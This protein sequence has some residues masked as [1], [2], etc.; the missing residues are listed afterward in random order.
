[1]AKTSPFVDGVEE[2]KWYRPT[3]DYSTIVETPYGKY[4]STDGMSVVT[5]VQQPHGDFHTNYEYHRIR[6]W[7]SG[8]GILYLSKKDP[9]PYPPYYYEE[10]E[11][12]SLSFPVVTWSGGMAGTSSVYHNLK[13]RASEA[14][15]Q[16]ILKQYESWDIMT[17]VAELGETVSL[18]KDGVSGISN[19][20][21]GLM[22]KDPRLVLRAFGVRS[23][24]KRV[25]HVRRVIRR[26]SPNDQRV[27]SGKSAIK[28]AGSLWLTYRYGIMPI[29]YSLEDAL[30]VLQTD[31]ISYRKDFQVTLTDRYKDI[32]ARQNDRLC[33]SGYYAF[34]EVHYREGNISCRI[35]ASVDFTYSLRDALRLNFLTIG[36][37]AWEV[38]P[39]SFVVDWFYDIGTYLES[40]ELPSLISSFSAVRSTRDRVTGTS[41]AEGFRKR[42]QQG[43]TV[44]NLVDVTTQKVR[45]YSF[46]RDIPV[47]ST[48]PPRLTWGIDRWKRE[49]DTISLL[50]NFI[51]H[52]R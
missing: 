1:M 18:L 11:W 24:R 48:A 13:Q 39:L 50:T 16:N 14:M 28:A 6:T 22:K 51:K 27:M 32:L 19:I 31:Q 7:T 42:V 17:D 4:T 44:E 35:R 47:L 21:K 46:E 43:F 23:T 9:V 2:L 12:K 10:R 26:Y 8:A 3:G 5:P 15:T 41:K 38:V 49:L 29:V 33:F 34:D 52:P 25:R 37:V 20:L 45:V 40:L 30:G 36:K